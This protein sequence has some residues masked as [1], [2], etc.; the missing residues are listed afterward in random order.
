MVRPPGMVDVALVDDEAREPAGP[1]AA[2]RAGRGR[3]R[4]RRADPGRRRRQQAA[5][6]GALAVVVALAV[7]VQAE[8]EAAAADDARVAALADVAGTV[9][10]LRTPP[11]DRRG[12]PGDR[13]TTL[14]LPDG[15]AVGPQPVDGALRTVATAPDGTTRWVAPA[16]VDAAGRGAACEPAAADAALLTC[17]VPGTPGVAGPTTDAVLGGTPD[18]LLVL[19]A[20]DGRVHEEVDLGPGTID[21]APLED[22]LVVARR[23][24]GTAEI[25]RRDLL[26]GD[27]WSVRVP[28]P[29][30]V[31]ARHLRVRVQD[32]LVVLTGPAAAVLD[33]DGTVLGTWTAPGAR[34]ISVDVRTSAVGFAVW[35]TPELGTWYDRTGRAGVRLEGA[36]VRPAVDDG[37]VPQVLLLQ[38][39]WTLRA[40]DVVTGPLWERRMP[41]A[42]P[43]RLDGLVVLDEGD[44]L[45]AVDVASGEVAWSRPLGACWDPGA[46]VTDGVRLAVPDDDDACARTVALDLHDGT[47]RWTAAVPELP[48]D[49]ATG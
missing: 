16:D 44:E 36:P 31:L 39:G 47:E 14:V 23:V 45:T 27:A 4:A 3:P 41:Q 20:A 30:W 5:V 42:V 38:D 10:S 33:A 43:A 37:S 34:R 11:A 49:Q 35:A 12:W 40:L 22:D 19:G 26:G 24:A 15:T 13:S 7:G 28:L 1:D 21:W 29:A 2:A 8:R 32:G 46:V 25:T 48:D 17:V 9:P 18:R 6:A